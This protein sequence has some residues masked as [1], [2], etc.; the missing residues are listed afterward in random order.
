MNRSNLLKGIEA[1]PSCNIILEVQVQ[2][3][4][5]DNEGWFVS[6]GWTLLNLFDHRR[7]LDKGVWKLPLY[8]SPTVAHLDVRDINTLKA[9]P[10]TVLCLRICNAQEHID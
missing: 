4:N 5:Q 1:H 8:Q 6:F 9:I 3:A 2:Q 7:D 10:S